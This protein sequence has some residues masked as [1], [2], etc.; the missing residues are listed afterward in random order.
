MADPLECRLRQFAMCGNLAAVDCEQRRLAV[1]LIDD[2]LVVSRDI[3][4]LVG[5]IIVK[6][7]HAR[8][9]PH[10]FVRCNLIPEIVVRRPAQV[11]D[12]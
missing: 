8:K 11:G 9:G 6:R 2:K 10:Q 12:F 5:T 7:T 4:R 1:A 3:F